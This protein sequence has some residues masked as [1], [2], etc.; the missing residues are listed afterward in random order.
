MS[1]RF[2]FASALLSASLC[3]AQS[4]LPADSGHFVINQ[5]KQA[6]GR[7]DFSIS[8]AQQ[9]GYTI[10][11][12]GNVHLPNV[13]YAFSGAGTLDQSLSIV[14]QSLNGTVNGQAV[15]FA[16]R[17]D[18]NNFAID[19]S[20]NGK[21]FH[22]SIARPAQTVF[23]PDFDLSSYE[24]ALSVAG[25]HPGQAISAL[26][27]KQ[28]GIVAS[29]TLA[30]QANVQ[31]TFN[32]KSIPVHHSSLTIGAVTSEL[33]FSADNRILE[34]DIPSQTFAI[35]HDNFQLQQPPPPPASAPPPNQQA[36]AGD[37]QPQ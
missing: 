13:T 3:A 26:V 25:M 5:G 35:V 20:A 34:V 6:V 23:F 2:L 7:S 10:T 36:P 33:Y 32:G 16:A 28:T 8:P 24:I 14:N 1:L 22:N 19:I 30:P 29:A 31:G 9:A 37:Q 18:G 17:A 27:P 4:A 12:H 21:Q 11:T 15:T